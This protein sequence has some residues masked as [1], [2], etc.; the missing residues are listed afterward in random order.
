MFVAARASLMNWRLFVD[1]RCLPCDRRNREPQHRVGRTT[2]M[3]QPRAVQVPSRA[4]LELA[5]GP[6]ICGSLSRLRAQQ[7]ATHSESAPQFGLTLQLTHELGRIGKGPR[8][9]PQALRFHR[10]KWKRWPRQWVLSPSTAGHRRD[11]AVELFDNPPKL[12]PL[13][14]RQD[15]S[16]LGDLLCLLPSWTY[17]GAID[18]LLALCSM[19]LG[20]WP[21]CHSP[22]PEAR[23]QVPVTQIRRGPI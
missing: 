11:H 6:C 14:G 17:R 23:S 3:L 21:P 15:R 16:A 7:L 10:Y 9:R 22:T 4:T 5:S 12:A 13:P 8:D 2:G 20:C 18:A 1:S 19:P